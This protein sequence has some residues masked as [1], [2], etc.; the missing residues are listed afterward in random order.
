MDPNGL[1]DPF[2][3][4]S[5]LKPNGEERSKCQKTE[6]KEKT[7]DPIFDESF[8]FDINDKELDHYVYV[9]VWDWDRLSANDFIGGMG[10]KVGDIIT[11]TCEGQK[12]DSWY[13]LLGDNISRSKSIRIISNEEAEQL[14]DEYRKTMRANKVATLKSDLEALDLRRGSQL[15]PGARD[16][17]KMHLDDF[18]LIVVLGKGSFGKV[19]L[20]EHKSTKE[21][22][23]IKSLKKDLIVQED[24]IECTLNERKVLALQG[25]PPFLTSLHS[26]FHTRDHLFFVMEFINGGDLMFHILELGT[27]PEPQTRFY[28]AEIVLGLL[29]LH[30]QGIVYRDLKL[31]NVMLDSEGHIKIADFGLCKDNIGDGKKTRTFCGT[32]DYIAPEVN[33]KSLFIYIAYSINSFLLF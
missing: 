14:I 32:P 13:K 25:K 10:L 5:L 18:K 31:D 28:A 20:A 7:L 15:V 24:D 4:V 27:F 6:R 16:L 8:F 30:E 12:I 22:Y 3:K 1:A 21:I 29:Y 9:A 11:E 23:A 33:D 26:C 2:V 19:F 17:P